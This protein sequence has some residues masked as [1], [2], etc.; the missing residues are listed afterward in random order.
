MVDL[1]ISEKYKGKGYALAMT[2]FSERDLVING[3]KKIWTWVWHSN[4]PSIR[5]FEKAG[6]VYSHQ[7]IELQLYG[8]ESHLRIKL[9]AWKR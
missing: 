4:G 6:W 8:M 2:L 7:L 3:Y 9:P 1:L 5:V